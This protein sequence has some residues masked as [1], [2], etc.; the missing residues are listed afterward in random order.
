MGCLSS[1][2]AFHPFSR[3]FSLKK[4]TGTL[5][6]NKGLAKAAGSSQRVLMVSISDAGSLD[7]AQW[8]I[9]RYNVTRFAAKVE[10]IFRNHACG[11]SA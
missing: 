2:S 1:P 10:L 7:L 11:E 9:V 6:K 4:G 3:H 5:F 8:N